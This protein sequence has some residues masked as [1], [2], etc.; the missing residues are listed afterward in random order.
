MVT[1]TFGGWLAQKMRSRG[2]SDSQVATYIGRSS[3]T[4]GRWKRNEIVPN[5]KSCALLA[6]LFGEPVEKVYALA[7]HPMTYEAPPAQARSI[8]DQA[9]EFISG[10][11]VAVP[12]YDQLA[13]AGPGQQILDYV[14]LEPG[15]PT[16]GSIVAIRVKG[17]SMEPDIRDGDYVVI[18]TKASAQPGEY[19]V[20]SA[21]D[22]VFVK[23]LRKRG[24]RLIL[25][26]TDGKEVADDPQVAGVVIQT[27]HNMR[28]HR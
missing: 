9:L 8:Q 10:L 14:Y 21:G 24:D 4:V 7:G 27:I 18:D 2:L 5:P 28:R 19:V 20:A 16:D 23:Q 1:E 15:S 3:A 13:S 11:P 17:W 25:V 22:E 26:G 6:G 12:V